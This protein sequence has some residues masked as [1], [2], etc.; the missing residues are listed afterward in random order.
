[1]NLIKTKFY[2]IHI[3]VLLIT[4]ACLL[5]NGPMRGG[6]PIDT[7]VHERMSFIASNTGLWTGAWVVWMFCALGLLVFCTI[8]SDELSADYL[9]TIGLFLVALGVAP[10][11]TA[12]VIYAFVLPK[13][14]YLQLGAD[15]YLLFEHIAAHL[16]GYLGNGLYNLGGMLL[17][18]LAFKQQVFKLWVFL[19]GM[20]AWSLGLALSASIALDALKFAEM[21]T[22]ASM[23]LSTLWMLIFAYQ[24][25]KPKWITHY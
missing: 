9:K 19:W 8:L 1:M 10:D 21:F 24:V 5:M 20:L 23:V 18:V 3:I 25:L 2:I 4:L 17:T 11:L 15:T 6:L 16:T 22:A 14:I 12:E 13:I 7:T